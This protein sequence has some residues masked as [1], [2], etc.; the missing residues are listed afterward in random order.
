MIINQ[1][2]TTLAYR[3]PACGS[4]PTSMVGA[5]SL[6]GDLF[7]LKCSCGQ[8]HMVVEKL[9]DDKLRLTVPCVTCPSPHV[10][11]VS[12]DVF[13]NSDVFVIPCSLC[14]VDICFIGKEQNVS[15]AIK[16][17][18]DEILRALGDNSLDSLKNDKKHELSDPQVVEIITYVVHELNDEGKI[19]CGCK[20]DEGEYECNIYSDFVT[21]KCKKCHKS[22]TI[23]ADS[24]IAAHDFLNA[25]KL[26]LS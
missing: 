20:E 16:R 6:S 1:K 8:S 15:D 23:P 3:C 14:G 13:F 19:F 12:K 18:N 26:T 7:K 10:Y 5:F 9:R 25:D 4:V 22:A 2:K 24:T 17:S 11:N 21:V